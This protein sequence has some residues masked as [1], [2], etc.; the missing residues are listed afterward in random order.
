MLISPLHS[1]LSHPEQSGLGWQAWQQLSEHS[2]LPVYALGGV[3]PADLVDVQHAGG[4]G[5]AG[6]RAFYNS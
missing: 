5:V 4:F 1:T 2:Q 3:T 6:I